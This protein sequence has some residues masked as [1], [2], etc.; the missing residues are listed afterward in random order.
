MEQVKKILFAKNFMRGLLAVI[1]SAFVMAW[2]FNVTFKDIPKENIRIV[3]T[4]LG[5]L[6]G[7]I[8]G[9]I[10]GYYFATSQSSTDKSE[11]ISEL[12]NKTS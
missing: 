5:F 6:M 12:R 4:I 2:L 7:T 1:W 9:G 11:V 3:D 10:F 8:I